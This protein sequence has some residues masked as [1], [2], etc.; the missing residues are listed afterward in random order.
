MMARGDVKHQRKTR[1]GEYSAGKSG[2]AMLVAPS[3]VPGCVG[4]KAIK[5]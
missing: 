3:C 4:P 2:G 5:T 1:K